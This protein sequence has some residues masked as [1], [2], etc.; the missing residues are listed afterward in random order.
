[1]SISPQGGARRLERL[2]WL[3]Y[4]NVQKRQIIFTLGLNAVKNTDFMKKSSSKSCLE[5]NSLQKVMGCICL[6]SPGVELGGSKDWQVR[7][8]I[9]QGMEEN[10][11]TSWFNA[12]GNTDYM[13]KKVQIKI[14]QIP[15]SYI[16][17]KD[18]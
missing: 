7:S 1:M 11:L 4:Y 18:V 14:V 6:F 5:L 3:K 9:M 15:I 17:I 12:A 8:I 13:K 2:T 10:R 16:R